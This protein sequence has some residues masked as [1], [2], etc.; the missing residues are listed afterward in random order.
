MH[1]ELIDVYNEN[2][3]KIGEEMKKEA[4]RLWLWHKSIHCWLFTRKDGKN[5][6][7]LQ[8]RAHEKLL[9]PDYYDVSVAGHYELGED[10]KDG[11]CELEEEFG[12]T[13]PEES[14]NY[15]GVKF[16]V[17]IAPNA[18]NKEFCEV[19]FTEI[20]TPLSSFT[21]NEREVGAV[22]T[23]AVE[24]GL[25]LFHGECDE[26]RAEGFAPDDKGSTREGEFIITR[27]SVIP[28]TDR[29]YA[30]IFAIA[31]LYFKGYKYLNI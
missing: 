21:L 26:I 1:E 14:W 31:D 24:D 22:V 30:K 6:V 11:L 2:M 19:Y 4:H 23:V 29:Y 20:D 28:R 16:D 15:L 9:M 3:E 8:R 10:G 7:I 13:V 18:I 12:I 27:E 17:G 25:K 5:Y